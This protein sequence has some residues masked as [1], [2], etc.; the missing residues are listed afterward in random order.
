MRQL[1]ST[2][3]Y[4]LVALAAASV[5]V[6]YAES[7]HDLSKAE[8][9]KE[10]ESTMQDAMKMLGKPQMKQMVNGCSMCTWSDK[11][12]AVTAVFGKDGKLMYMKT[13]KMGTH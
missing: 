8:Q 1:H 7:T 9:L 11:N 13:W 3:P 12:M 10:G 5:S 2:A 6:V 4:L